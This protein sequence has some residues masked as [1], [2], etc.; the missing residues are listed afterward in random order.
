MPRTF[1]VDSTNTSRLARRMFVV[2]STNTSRQIKRMFVIDSTNTA[3]LVF[4][5]A[6]T[7]TMV[8][9]S[10]GPGSDIFGYSSSGAY[11]SLT[12][13]TDP[14]LNTVSAITWGG[15]S[16]AVLSLN[17]NVTPNPGQFYVYSLSLT[18]GQTVLATAASYGYSTGT[19]QWVWSYPGPI[20]FGDTY[21]CVLTL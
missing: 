14:A 10:G 2:D 15:P 8:A 17:I 20:N 21:T 13:N 11:G 7:M 1:I 16:G 4:A 3:R 5:P 6:V 18:P 19:A 12:P 9:G